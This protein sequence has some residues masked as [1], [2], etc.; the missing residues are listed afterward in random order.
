VRFLLAAALSVALLGGC[1]GNHGM[2]A[3][4]PVNIPSAGNVQPFDIFIYN[5]TQW[6][7]YLNYQGQGWVIPIGTTVDIPVGYLPSGVTVDVYTYATPSYH[8]PTQTK[9]LGVDYAPTANSVTF[10][11]Y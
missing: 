3:A 5:G 6:P 2:Q 7:L 11:F 8:Y 9:T 10:S 1:N 4:Y